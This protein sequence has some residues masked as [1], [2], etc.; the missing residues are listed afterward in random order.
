[1]GIRMVNLLVIAGFTLSWGAA[2]NL[3]QDDN[4][5]AAEAQKEKDTKK[6][7]DAWV[8]IVAFLD[9][10]LAAADVEVYDHDGKLLFKKQMA[11]NA[12]GA[13]PA[14]VKKLP[15][16]FRVVVSWEPRRNNDRRPLGG[17]DLSTDV[18]DFDPANDIVYVNAVTTLVSRV[19][20]KAPYLSVRK[21]QVLVRRFLGLQPN[22]S[23]GSA[24]RQG[25][26]YRSRH[27]S[28]PAFLTEAI[29]IGGVDAFLNRLARRILSGPKD[30]QLFVGAPQGI[31]STAATFVARNLASGALSWAAGQGMGWVAQSAG[32]STRGATVADIANL[33]ASLSDLQSSIDDLKD[34]IANLQS[35]L[36]AQISDAGY[37]TIV[38][39]AQALQGPVDDAA[40]RLNFYALGCPTVPEG[41]T[42]AP[43]DEW[44]TQNRQLIIDRLNQLNGSFESLAN[45][46]LDNSV[47]RYKGLIHMYS[48]TLGQAVRFFRPADSTKLQ[49]NFD[50]WD[51]ALVQAAM[52]KT[53]FFHM[54]GNQN[55]PGG[56]AELQ[57]FLGDPNASPPIQGRFPTTRSQMALLNFPPLPEGTVI[58]TKDKKMWSTTAPNVSMC[59]APLYTPAT[60]SLTPY[61]PISFGG[62][63]GWITPSV[64]DL[65]NLASGFTGVLFDWLRTQTQT[66]DGES[67]VSAGFPNILSTGNYLCDTFWWSTPITSSTVASANANPNTYGRY[68][69]MNPYNGTMY[70]P[71]NT[72]GISSS[73]P[74]GGW[75]LLSRALSAGEQYYWYP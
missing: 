57:S 17:F 29:K 65:Q 74:S 53:E 4:L 43:P 12:Q 34:D 7:R 20:D 45:L 56:I 9:V 61:G 70:I 60:N 73:N 30:T 35:A 32:L 3:P 24:L 40:S 5:A 62:I 67:P 44:C 10:P 13:F 63:S 39:Q 42:P 49:A 55:N 26:Y 51:A 75:M 71:T 21:S 48:Q 64:P 52:L 11:T 46:V 58:N 18:R 22:Q 15:R 19:I 27:F 69:M 8:P 38:A 66:V 33:Q 37:Q 41:Q 6:P 14:H 36:S 68:F 1:M 72:T 2:Q 16:N 47:T 23:L 31:A 54:I 25:K 50:Y 28:H 59:S